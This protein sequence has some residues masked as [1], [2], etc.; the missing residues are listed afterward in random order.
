MIRILSVILMGS[1][2]SKAALAETPQEI[3]LSSGIAIG[4]NNG[5]AAG[6]SDISN[7][8]VNPAL[9]AREQ[10]YTFSGSVTTPSN[11]QSFYDVGILD[12]H[13]SDVAIA[14]KGRD[15]IDDGEDAGVSSLTPADRRFGLGFAKKVSSV[16]VGIS[17]HYAKAS[18]VENQRPIDIEL[19][20]LGVGLA[21]EA[22]EG[23]EWGMSWQ[24]LQNR[25]YDQ[26]SP[27][28]FRAGV[29]YSLM[30]NFKLMFD[31]VNTKD[32]NYYVGNSGESNPFIGPSF[33]WEIIQGLSLVGS[34]AWG[35]GGDK[36]RHYAGGLSYKYNNWAI[37]YYA[38]ALEDDVE[39]T[40]SAT[41]SYTAMSL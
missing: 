7:I 9:L 39:L 8:D 36:S 34:S 23:L 14:L 35:L 15:F 32:S 24:N 16:Y 18:I 37:S 40:S 38:M 33:Q 19:M 3:F 12:S 27:Y 21:G 2:I 41:L 25:G 26:V 31:Y 10:T 1:L 4:L 13:T 17:A 5:G 20:T 22:I 6:P 29:S 30:P 11:G 28:T